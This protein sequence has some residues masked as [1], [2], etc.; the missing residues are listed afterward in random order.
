MKDSRISSAFVIT[1][2]A[3]REGGG[4]LVRQ[5]R[6]V[7][8]LTSPGGLWLR[9]IWFWTCFRP[10][11]YVQWLKSWKGLRVFFGAGFWGMEDGRKNPKKIHNVPL[12]F[13]FILPQN[14]GP[15][16]RITRRNNFLT[17]KSF[18]K[19]AH[20]QIQNARW[21]STINFLKNY[22][23]CT[24]GLSVFRAEKHPNRLNTSRAII[25]WTT[26][27][28]IPRWKPRRSPP[29][30]FKFLHIRSGYFTYDKTH[31]SLAVLCKR[32]AVGRDIMVNTLPINSIV[33]H[34]RQ[35]VS[36]NGKR[37]HLTDENVQYTSI[38][39]FIKTFWAISWLFRRSRAGV[40]GKSRRVS[41][42]IRL[43]TSRI[44]FW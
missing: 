5:R 6:E 3:E 25:I 24:K 8:P 16:S 28:E 2:A 10:L 23:G 22:Q 41:T 14:R 35:S 4:F 13:S 42:S 30:S 36:L 1:A 44:S 7:C 34:V 29:L 17:K 26:S 38:Y 20:L 21:W 39:N 32:G 18:G 11:K 15:I 19:Y 37:R 33:L 9:K 12:T 31:P 40:T 27:I 43:S